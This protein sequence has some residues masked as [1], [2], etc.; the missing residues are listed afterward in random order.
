MKE[1]RKKNSSNSRSKVDLLGF[2]YNV[3]W[4]IY[5]PMHLQLI[6]IDL[7]FHGLHLILRYL[8]HKHSKHKIACLFF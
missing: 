2:K 1:G 4:M 8:F 6:P 7:S 5:I 3:C